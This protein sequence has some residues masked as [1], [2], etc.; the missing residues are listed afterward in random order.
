MRKITIDG[1][2]IECD[3]SVELV[4]EGRKVTIK[5]AAPTV[6]YHY[7]PAQMPQQFHPYAFTVPQMTCTNTSDGGDPS[8]TS[9]YV[10]VSLDN[11]DPFLPNGA[12]AL[13]VH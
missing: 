6:V 2:Q 7:Y 10:P 8:M 11:P 5:A 1:V 4:I 3:D 13:M 9:G 12:F